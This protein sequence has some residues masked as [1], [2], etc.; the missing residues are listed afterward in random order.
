M[1]ELLSKN[2][3]A[4]ILCMIMAIVLWMYVMNEQN[5]PIEASFTIPIEVKNLSSTYTLM[6]GP[7][8]VRVK[9]R[10]ARSIIATLSASDIAAYVD[11]KGIG[12]GRHPIKIMAVVPQSVELVEVNPDKALLRIDIA[13]SRKLPVEVRYTSAP[14]DNAIVGKVTLS[15]DTVIV[16]GPKSLLDSI[17]KAIIYMD[18]SEHSTDFSGKFTVHI[19]N[20]DGKELEDV[21][22]QP[23]QINVATQLLAVN[24]KLV[25]VKPVFSGELPAGMMMKQLEVTPNKIELS[26]SK[27]LL[28]TVDIVTTEPIV[29]T[30]DMKEFNR[31]IKVIAKDGISVSPNAITV[32]FIVGPTR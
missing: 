9:V 3:A 14:P 8:S 27:A 16:E 28:D 13:T 19:I 15:P 6:D 30:S 12:E 24:K 7:E 32:K 20:T 25:D 23:G 10:G 1:K 29:L 22:A 2:L 21:T 5:P 31:Q 11:L 17:D 18:L 4:K 26:G